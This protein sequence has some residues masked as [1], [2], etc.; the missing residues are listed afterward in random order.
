VLDPKSLRGRLTLAYV[1]TLVVALVVFAAAVLLTVDQIQRRALD[2]ELET[3]ARALSVAAEHESGRETARRA[4]SE[5]ALDAGHFDHPDE[6]EHGS[7]AVPPSGERRAAPVLPPESAAQRGQRLRDV[8]QFQLGQLVGL[9]QNAAV[10]A[11]DGSLFVATAVSIPAAVTKLARTRPA[12]LELADGNEGRRYFRI[13]AVP[14]VGHH[15]GGTVVAWRGRDIDELLDRQ[16][17]LVFGL[18]IPFVA[19]LALMG[20]NA[21]AREGL[22]PLQR[23]AEVA[24]EIEA[25][26][27]SRR[28]GL[29]PAGDELGRLAE[30]FDRMLDRLQSSFARERRFTSDASHEIRAPLSVLRASADYALLRER[31]PAAYRRALQTILSEADE[32]EAVTRDLLAVARAE[33]ATA[34]TEPVDLAAIAT[35]AASRLSVLASERGVTFERKLD[36]AA[37]GMGDAGAFSRVA[38]ALLHNA[39]KYAREGGRV[40]LTAAANADA[41]AFTVADDGPGFSPEALRHATERFWRDDPS[42]G[43]GQGT[44]LGLAIARAAVEAM[45][46]SLVLGNRPQGGAEVTIRLPRYQAPVRSA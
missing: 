33:T 7:L 14:I 29:P 21:I 3:T 41:V 43:R 13:A 32:L 16:L 12:A 24:S 5:A 4:P 45:G 18:A 42:R 22:R 34:T 26:D 17:L 36:A 11:P 2:R 27:L 38:L 31:D 30:A 23:M 6:R 25:K 1:A 28:I 9:G 20:G 39:L 8:A 10:F 40:E 44:G 19:V 46:G 35:A 37:L 15:G